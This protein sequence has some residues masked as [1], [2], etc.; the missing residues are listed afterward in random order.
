METNADIVENKKK[1][2]YRLMTILGVII[3][4]VGS[5]AIALISNSKMTGLSDKYQSLSL[6]YESLSDSVK[7]VT[8]MVT[9]TVYPVLQAQ[10]S[11]VANFNDSIDACRSYFTKS[12]DKQK[13]EVLSYVNS[14]LKKVDKNIEAF[15]HNQVTF[16]NTF[17]SDLQN[18]KCNLD[19]LDAKVKT[20][21]PLILPVDTQKTTAGDKKKNTSKKL[22]FGNILG[23]PTSDGK[24]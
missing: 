17:N 3:F 18:V 9:D 22:R 4:G 21:A 12:L 14:K 16:A 7:A 13:K 10:Q 2:D 11:Y 24:K 19:T 6:K 20:P 15:G 23:T 1:K 5:I 8:V